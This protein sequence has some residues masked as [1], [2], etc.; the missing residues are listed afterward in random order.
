MCLPEKDLVNNTPKI[1]NIIDI[2]IYNLYFDK[3][4][5]TYAIADYYIYPFIEN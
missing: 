4:F 5:K 2:Y 1:F 3:T